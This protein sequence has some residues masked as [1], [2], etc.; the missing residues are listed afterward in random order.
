M[1]IDVRIRQPR[2]EPLTAAQLCLRFSGYAQ[3]Y[4][5]AAVEL[6]DFK[7]VSVRYYLLGHAFELILKSYILSQGAPEKKIRKL[8]HSLIEANDEAKRLG[9]SPTD[10]RLRTIVEWLDP[11]HENQDFRYANHSGHVILPKAED[12]FAV[13]KSTY[14]D[15]YP[16]ARAFYARQMP[17]ADPSSG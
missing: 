4:A 10:R 9:Y 14:S 12:A 6:A 13:F 17:A 5:E 11:F 8:N 1:A 16:L 3:D 2:P 7:F 15:V